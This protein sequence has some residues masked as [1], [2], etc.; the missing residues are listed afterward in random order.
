M[1]LTKIKKIEEKDPGHDLQALA[2]QILVAL[3]GAFKKILLYSPDHIIYQTSLNSLKNILDNFLDRHGTLVLTIDRNKVRYKGEVVHEGPMKD[4]NPAFILF[5]DGIYHLEFHKSIELWEIH[6][7][8]EILQKYQI[9]TDNAEGDVVTSLWEL[10]LPS[11]RYK[12]EDMDFDTGEDFEIPE[13]GDFEAAEDNSE[14]LVSDDDNAESAPSFYAPIH[15]RNF[16]EITP[17]DRDH[18]RN[19]LREEE[20]R[21]RIE[22]VL[23]ILMHILQQQTQPDDFSEVMTFINQELQEAMKSHKYQSVFNT[24]E[25]FRRN[26][27]LHKDRDHWIIHVLKDFFASLSGKTFLSVMHDDWGSIA[28]CDPQELT[29]LKRA[30]LLLN[31]DA[32]DTLGPMLLEIESNQTKKM[33]MAVIGILAE[34]EFKHLENLLSSSDTDMVKMLVQIMRFM[35]SE[36]SFKRLLEMLRHSSKD[37]RKEALK[38]IFAR[39]S[40]IIAELPWLIDDPDEDVQQLFLKYAGQHRDLKTERL[41]LDYLGK[42]RIRSRKKQLLFRVYISLGKC[43]SDESIPFL[44]KNLFFLPGLGILRPKKSL[45]RQAAVYAL[46]ELNTEKAELMLDRTSKTLRSNVNEAILSRKNEQAIP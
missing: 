25:I 15:D 16:W 12:V 10:E 23:Y 24:L 46:K 3:N 7:F 6:S 44:K 8:L 9:L 26:L 37:V 33:F 2:K 29:Y 5:R 28:E 4:V 18:L 40:G 22:H 30:L 31:A 11:L 32:I 14:Q 38:A 20:N 43:G 19:M 35:K 39:N 21:D 45:R 17:E 41:L 42:K 27:N 36:Q 13:L 34:R 1:A